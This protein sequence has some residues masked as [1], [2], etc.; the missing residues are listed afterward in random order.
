MDTHFHK[1]KIVKTKENCRF[2]AQLMKYDF[3]ADVKKRS[4]QRLY[5]GTLT[6]HMGEMIIM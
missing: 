1:S 4:K 2:P 5:R 6:I 3:R